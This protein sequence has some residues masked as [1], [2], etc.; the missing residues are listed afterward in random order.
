MMKRKKERSE[1]GGW[2]LGFGQENIVMLCSAGGEAVFRK[3]LGSQCK[4][5]PYLG[6]RPCAKT[7]LSIGATAS[8]ISNRGT[9]Q[10]GCSSRWDLHSA[11]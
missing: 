6:W 1:N 9:Y 10:V 3:I 8:V 11:L 7:D 2:G 5:N 4:Y